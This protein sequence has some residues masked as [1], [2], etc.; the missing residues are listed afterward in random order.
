[1]A[2]NKLFA[3]LNSN[4]YYN[5]FCHKNEFERLIKI[6]ETDIGSITAFSPSY[7]SEILPNVD[8]DNNKAELL[9]A[10]NRVADFC[11]ALP[12]SG[13]LIISPAAYNVWK[14]QNIYYKSVKMV[15]AMGLLTFMVQ[16]HYL[17]ATHGVERLQRN[18]EYLRYS[19]SPE[20][21]VSVAI[22][23]A[24][25]AANCAAV[26]AQL[27]L[28]GRLVR[29]FME[30]DRSSVPL[31]SSWGIDGENVDYEVLAS[32]LIDAINSNDY[33]AID[34]FLMVVPKEMKLRVL[35]STDVL[36]GIGDQNLDGELISKKIEGLRKIVRDKSKI[37]LIL[38]ILLNAHRK[39][40]FKSYSFK[41]TMAMLIVTY[42]GQ[43]GFASYG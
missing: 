42:A 10:I 16:A 32:K 19:P 35:E 8:V 9:K 41:E 29:H 12:F 23:L 27:H 39:N 33:Q 36:R 43:F 4:L 11:N 38:R 24:Y 13:K 20:T 26:Y 30:T 14:E 34:D 17:Q 1:M 21:M 40:T 5:D 28:S 3:I 15:E 2:T 22:D 7:E 18:I 6:M 25:T 31:L 37:R